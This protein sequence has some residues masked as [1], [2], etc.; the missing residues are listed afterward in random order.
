MLKD[1]IYIKGKTYTKWE[2]ALCCHW[3][4][5]DV[6]FC[7]KC[8]RLDSDLCKSL[9][10]SLLYLNIPV[11][12]GCKMS[13]RTSSLYCYI[14]G[15]QGSWIVCLKIEFRSPEGRQ[16]CSIFHYHWLTALIKPRLLFFQAGYAFWRLSL[17]SVKLL[18][19]NY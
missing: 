4:E 13:P 3:L 12:G 5:C 8:F 9:W 11:Y 14:S 6:L 1:I 19:T 16:W 2:Y 15:P 18:N 10:I 7:I 17:S